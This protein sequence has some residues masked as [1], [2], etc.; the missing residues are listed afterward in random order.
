MSCIGVTLQNLSA[1]DSIVLPFSLLRISPLKRDIVEGKTVQMEPTPYEQNRLL[2]RPRTW[3]RQPDLARCT[4]AC[5]ARRA[6]DFLQHRGI[7][8]ASGTNRRGVPRLSSDKNDPGSNRYG[9]S[10][11][12][13][14]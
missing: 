6:G 5:T 12:Q 8:P 2:Q 4:G 10:G 1:P 14:C 11:R 7:P 3:T 13:S 9:G